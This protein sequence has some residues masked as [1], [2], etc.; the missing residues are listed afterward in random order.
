MPLYGA[1]V[2]MLDGSNVV[3]R[4]MCH[5]LGMGKPMGLFVERRGGTI[6]RKLS[7]NGKG[8]EELRP[9]PL[10]DGASKT[11][12]IG[13]VVEAEAAGTFRAVFDQLKL[14]GSSSKKK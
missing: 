13:V 4:S 3:Y 8:F 6:T 12:K 1:G 5:P 10:P 14:T 9:L 7:I 2:I 11:L